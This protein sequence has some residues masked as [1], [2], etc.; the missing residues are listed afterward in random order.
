MV[1]GAIVGPA[2][3]DLLREQIGIRNVYWVVASLAGVSA[4]LVLLFAHEDASKRRSAEGGLRWSKLLGE[5]WADLRELRTNRTL[6]AAIVLTFW[7]QFGLGA[8]NPLIELYVRDVGEGFGWLEPTTG[9][10]FSA[11]AIA[12]LVAMPL[13][14]AYG[15]RAGAYPALLRCAGFGAAALALHGLAPGFEVLLLAR[16][17]YGA[18]MAGSG[19]LAF[20][21][22]AAESSAEQRGGAI[23]VVFAAR[24]LSVATSSM[25]G[26]WLS[27]WIGIRGLYFVSAAV[28]V[29][30][31]ALVG[32]TLPQA[33]IE[34]ARSD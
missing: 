21:V 3:G 22:A 33:S 2:L 24:T 29:G 16:V 6:R 27:A 15:D 4:L 8:T 28:L 7:I 31:V 32:R 5:S 9:A 14:G 23:G 17:A 34:S 18:A 11:M 1:L 25:L 12:N 13:W 26:G 30:Y 10:L 19:P 20:G